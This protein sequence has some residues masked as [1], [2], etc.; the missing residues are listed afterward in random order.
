MHCS[1]LMDLLNDDMLLSIFRVL[2][3]LPD[4]FSVAATCN[5]RERTRPCGLP[6]N[7]EWPSASCAPPH[8]EV[9]LPGNGQASMATC[10]T[11]PDHWTGRLA[12]HLQDPA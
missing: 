4:L 12:E 11:K 5:V 3:P 8:A 7:I 9:P 6:P 10:L 2:S 1:S